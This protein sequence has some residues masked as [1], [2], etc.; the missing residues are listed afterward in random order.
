MDITL[1]SVNIFWVWTAENEATRQGVR[2]CYVLS[3]RI[4]L[5]FKMFTEMLRGE[6]K[7]CDPFRTFY[8]CSRL[9]LLTSFANIFEMEQYSD[10]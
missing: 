5:H 4:L 1:A 9:V 7:M 8:V 10:R 3:F 2:F 6:R